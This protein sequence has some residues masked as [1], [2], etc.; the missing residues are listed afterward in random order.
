M[1]FEQSF[2]TLKTNKLNH[3]KFKKRVYEKY[4]DFL[5]TW[6]ITVWKKWNQEYFVTATFD[7]KSLKFVSGCI[8]HK[9][10]FYIENKS[11]S[12][13]KDWLH[14]IIKFF[15]NH[16]LENYWFEKNLNYKSSFDIWAFSNEKSLFNEI[17][18]LNLKNVKI[19][20][21]ENM[22]DATNMIL[23]TK[24]FDILKLSKK[25]DLIKCGCSEQDANLLNWKF[26]IADW[27]FD[28]EDSTI[29]WYLLEVNEAWQYIL[30]KSIKILD[31]EFEGVVISGL[32]RFDIIANF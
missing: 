12:Y 16:K 8:N 18:F 26:F 1:D 6:M 13:Y 7:K 32:N 24:K 5:L 15:F 4:N 9:F 14:K 22:L 30:W 31:T 28:E 20:K 19:K 27:W 11:V 2:K 29:L 10:E 21:I 3:S 25:P 23:E 17:D